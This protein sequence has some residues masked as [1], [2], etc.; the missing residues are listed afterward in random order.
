MRG[1]PLGHDTGLNHVWSAT[2]RAAI[3]LVLVAAVASAHAAE[4]FQVGPFLFTEPQ[5]WR[6]MR[7]PNPVRKAQFRIRNPAGGND[8]IAIFF[9]FGPGVGGEPAANITRWYSHFKEP[10]AA[11]DATV[12]HVAID[13]GARHLFYARGTFVAA[14]ADGK[15]R[16]VPDHAL[17]AAMLESRDGAVFVRLV[18]PA[19]LAAG[20]RDAFRQMIVTARPP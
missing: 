4:T 13:G 12:E 6:R 15:R 17:L 18:A 1:G 10:R 19:A 11:L 20:V 5:D 2:R 14:G 3:G 9:H 16:E 8:G 7:P